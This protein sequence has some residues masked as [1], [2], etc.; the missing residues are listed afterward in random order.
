MTLVIECHFAGSQIFIVMSV[1][2]LDNVVLSVV[3]L[4]VFM[5]SVVAPSKV[6]RKSFNLFFVDAQFS[7]MTNGLNYKTFYGRN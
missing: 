6:Q 5:S 1:V 3:K 4:S 7:S 2:M